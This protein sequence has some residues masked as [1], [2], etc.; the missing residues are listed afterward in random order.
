MLEAVSD[1]SGSRYFLMKHM[2]SNF[3]E[4][5]KYLESLKTMGFI[6]VDTKDSQVLYR[7][8]EKGLD[9]LKQYYILLRMLLSATES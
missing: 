4:V 3:S 2:G 5:T 9:F 8:S 1:T 6:Y 7:T